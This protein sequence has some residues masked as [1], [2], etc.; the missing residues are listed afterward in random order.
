M[1]LVP[2]KIDVGF[3]L[4][5]GAF[6]ETGTATVKLS[7]LRCSARIESAGGVTMAS[8]TLQVFGMTLSMMNRLSTLG[9][10]VQ[11]IPRNTVTVEA[12]DDISGM[13]QVFVGNITHAFA[14]FSQTPQVPMTIIAHSL[15]NDSVRPVSPLSFQGKTDLATIAQKVVGNMNGGAG[16]PFRSNGISLQLSNPYLWGPPLMQ[17]RQLIQAGALGFNGGMDGTI[18]LWPRN[19]FNNIGGT[20]I[21]SP[22]TGMVGYPSFTPYGVVVRTVFNPAI[23]NGSQ[24]SIISSI[25][26]VPTGAWRVYALAHSLDAKVPRGDWFSTIWCNSP[27]GPQPVNP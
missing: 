21:V 13:T 22:Q 9:I 23:K 19:G 14:D 2:R 27:T 4:A 3:K 6:A 1:T 25:L 16:Y 5:N 11:L 24:L 7:G 26:P 17:L 8:M 20:S 15:L 12:G 18:A 10:Q